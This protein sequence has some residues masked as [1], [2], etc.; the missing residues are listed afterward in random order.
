MGAAAP[1]DDPYAWME[2]IEG[3]RPL[4]WARAENARSLP[5]LQNDPRY[6]GLYAD[7]LKIATAKDRIPAVA[8]RGDGVLRD[9]WQD[10]EHVR[11]LWRTTGLESY[12]TGKP[13]WRTLLDLD[14]LAKAENA[15]WVWNGSTCL[16]PD[17]RYCLISLSDGGKDAVEVRE[18]DTGAGKFVDG[19][20]RLPE[21][22]HRFDWIDKD[23]LFVVTD[24]TK[25]DVTTSGY[26]FIAKILKRGQTLDQAREVFRGA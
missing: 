8:F 20:F 3:T 23:T 10:A 13:E 17:D 22:K 15:N 26:P 12:R 7:A 14:A 6:A 25:A 9:Y 21:G 19:G 1:D 5:Q 16:R 24:W 4:E 11:G 18:F 2:E